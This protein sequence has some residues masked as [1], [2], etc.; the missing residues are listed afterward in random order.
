MLMEKLE[1]Q[2][3]LILEGQTGLARRLESIERRME[4]GYSELHKLMIDGFETVYKDFEKVDERFAGVNSRLD[5]L[6]SRFDA[7][8]QAHTS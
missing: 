8:E 7:H 6:T 5:A 4:D 1:P 2:V 3:Q